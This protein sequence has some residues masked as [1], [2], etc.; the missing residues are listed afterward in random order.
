MALPPY[1][2]FLIIGFRHN[3]TRWL[4]FNLDQHP[5][6]FAPPVHPRFFVSDEQMG[7]I[8]LRGYR[9]L[10]DGWRSPQV[11][12]E[13]SWEYADW[14]HDPTRTMVRVRKLL[15][16]VRLIAL[17]DDPVRRFE[18]AVGL[19]Q[20][21]GDVPLDVDIERFYRL[22]EAQEAGLRLLAEGMQWQCLRPYQEAFGDQLL[23][24]F[25][26]DVRAD[27][28]GTYRSVLRHIGADDSFVPP[29]IARPRFG[30]RGHPTP[31]GASLSA[32]QWIYAWNRDDVNLL[33]AA[34][35]RDLTAWDP[36]VGPD[37]PT[38]EQMMEILQQLALASLTTD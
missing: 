13:G 16:D 9:E 24:V 28:A 18:T 29:D 30:D 35:G 27:P 23:I 12:G 19:A 38:G 32:R 26:D 11:I 15:P 1:P 34:T 6:I 4:R 20:R 17:V 37:T 25:L 2:T 5:A 10:F 22:E 36:G 21:T 31:T 7:S 14:S 33:A 3:A 8:G